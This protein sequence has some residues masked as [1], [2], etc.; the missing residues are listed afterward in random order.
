MRAL[1]MLAF[2]ALVLGL[3]PGV[4]GQDIEISPEG[5]YILQFDEV[6]GERLDDF[7]DLAQ[8]ILQRPIKYVPSETGEANTRIFIIGPHGRT[9]S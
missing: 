8:K 5:D 3:A 4:S 2:G 6:N 1:R 9:C 7:I